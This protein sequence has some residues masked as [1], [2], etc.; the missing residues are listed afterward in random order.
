MAMKTRNT[1]DGK[2]EVRWS[3]WCTLFSL[4]GT[5][6]AALARAGAE[7]LGW[8]HSPGCFLDKLVLLRCCGVQM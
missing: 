6:V 4:A 7:R 3:M 1:D 2:I 5:V 8:L